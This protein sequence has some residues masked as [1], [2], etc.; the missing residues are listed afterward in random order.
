MMRD[1]N[2]ISFILVLC[3][4]M[5][6]QILVA[7]N[8][9]ELINEYCPVMPD[10]KASPSITV[11]YEGKTVN[12]CCKMC[13]RMFTENP[14]EY[15]DQLPQFVAAMT[16]PESEP[17]DNASGNDEPA[18]V[19]EVE[20][21]AEVSHDHGDSEAASS[22]EDSSALKFVG[23][24][25]PVFVH[26]PIAL[27]FAALVASLLNLIKPI[28][29]FQSAN[30]FTIIIA[31]LGAAIASPLGWSAAI[32]AVYPTLESVLSWHRWLGTASGALIIVCAI[33][34]EVAVRKENPALSKAYLI[35]LLI[36]V[37]LTGVASHFGATLVYGP[38]HFS[39]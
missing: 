36:T 7:Q 22:K 34:N 29:M 16:L 13:R 38:D 28:E 18:D 20:Q 1:Q 27:A 4:M 39:M 8:G 17:V 12:L 35:I 26:F 24:F 2:V 30:R 9:E 32:D 19:E 14:E 5:L 23:K 31:A 10:E 21:E 11:E 6:A 25:H 37:I 3:S 33:L 15:L